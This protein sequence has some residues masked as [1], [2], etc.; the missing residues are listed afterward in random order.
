MSGCSY[1][2]D[3]MGGE[4][5]AKPR[6]AGERLAVLPVAADLQPD[7]LM[8]ELAVTLPAPMLNPEWAQHGSAPPAASGNLAINGGLAAEES[9]SAGEGEAFSHTII[10]QPVAGGGMVF[11]IDAVGNISAH[12]AGNIDNV[13]WQS[14]GVAEED[15]PEIMGG[16]LAYAEGKLYATSGR[17]TVAA[18]DAATGQPIWRKELGIPFVSP[19]RVAGDRLFIITIDNQ[20]YAISAASGEALWSHRGISETAGMVSSVSPVLSGDTLIVPYSSG[21][22]YALSASTG[23]EI[24]ND[25]LSADKRTQATSGFSGIGG[26]PVVDGNIMFAVSNGGMLSVMHLVTAQPVWSRPIGA[27]NTPWL[28]GDFMYLLTADNTLVCFIKYSGRIRWATR[29][30]GFENEEKKLDPIV[31]RGPVLVNGKLAVVSSDGEMLLVSAADGTVTDTR[32][33]PE[34]IFTAPIVAG[35]VMY[36]IDQDATLHSLQ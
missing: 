26:D 32:S 18:F 7:E 2:P 22:L 24:W 27:I 4:P 1:L 29:L 14:V 33:V 13:R 23:R 36:L 12:E 17:G 30:R 21:E 5:E 35:G 10:P 3:W 34:G 20:L 6:L 16:G 11:V 19:P 9:V 15:E 8:K 31:W 25:S 28:A